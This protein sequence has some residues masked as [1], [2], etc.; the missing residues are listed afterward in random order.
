MPSARPWTVRALVAVLGTIWGLNFIF[1]KIGLDYSDPIWLAFLRALLGTAGTV[2]LMGPLRARGGL[3]ARG[4]RDAMLIG[5]PSM[6]VFYALLFVGITS[7]LPGFA[8]V[9]VYT[10]P[11]WVAMFSPGVL[12]HRV[13]TRVG[14]ALAIGFSGVILVSSPW[15]GTSSGVP[16]L[17]VVELLGAA[18]SWALGTVLFQRRFPREV[19][20]EANAYQL[21]GGT[22][23]LAVLVLAF[24]P[25]AF[26]R[27]T[28][29]LIGV[30]LWLGL[31]GT[32]GGYVIWSYLL[33]HTR[34]LTLSAY[35]F[36]VPIVALAASALIY[37][38]R[39]GPIAL[40][41]VALVLGSIYLIGSAPS[42]H[43]LTRPADGVP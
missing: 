42:A 35:V 7:V 13:T 5:L 1:L 39:L 18:A 36:L 40:L 22:V 4:R 9:L 2:A 20:L 29:E 38:E 15:T 6:T 12:G 25:T 10:F 23:G 19:L 34:A 37:D 32:T 21:V 28:P 41:G 8:S 24:A 43:D 31:L 16:K 11:L 3:D 27:F 17:A 30:V 33:G 14:L 26:P